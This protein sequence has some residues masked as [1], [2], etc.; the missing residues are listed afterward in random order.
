MGTMTLQKKRKNIDLPI[1]VL[2]K[3]SIMA[4]AQGKSLKAFIEN[5]LISKAD[6][7]KTEV[8][9][10]SPSDDDY[11]TDAANLTEVEE[12]VKTYREGKADTT[13]VLQSPEDITNF[14]NNL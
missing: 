10:P 6:A 1:D 9:N 7:L 2:Q 12:R 8:K 5:V 14:I 3:L 11:F 4:A 13:V